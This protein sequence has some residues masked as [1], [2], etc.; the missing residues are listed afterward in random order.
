[1]SQYQ[2][3]R[4]LIKFPKIYKLAFPRLFIYDIHSNLLRSTMIMLIAFSLYLN[5]IK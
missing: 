2:Y 4:I 5:I 3:D 1:M